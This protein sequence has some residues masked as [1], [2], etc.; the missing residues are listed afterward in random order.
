VLERV[1]RDG[2]AL[3]CEA[4]RRF[5]QERVRIRDVPRSMTVMVGV[6]IL[7]PPPREPPRRPCPG[8]EVPTVTVA[9]LVSPFGYV[10]ARNPRGT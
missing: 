1:A 3:A 10:N 6:V 9:R 8:D 7:K 5:T 4:L 2:V